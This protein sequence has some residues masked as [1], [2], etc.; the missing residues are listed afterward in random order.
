[1]RRGELSKLGVISVPVHALYPLVPQQQT[2]EE[3]ADM[4]AM[5][6]Y[7]CKSLFGGTNE[8]F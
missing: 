3:R 6:R 2:F 4:S 1:M 7:C 5:C 8:I